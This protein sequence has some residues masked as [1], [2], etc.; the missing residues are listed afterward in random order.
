[1]PGK[2]NKPSLLGVQKGFIQGIKHSIT[3]SITILTA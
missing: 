3:A 1:M 2:G